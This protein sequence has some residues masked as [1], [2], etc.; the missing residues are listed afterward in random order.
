MNSGRSDASTS[1][2]DVS[3]RPLCLFYFTHPFGVLSPEPPTLAA[4]PAHIA[5]AF[6]NMEPVSP[7]TMWGTPSDESYNTSYNT[8]TSSSRP[9]FEL[10]NA[11]VHAA[12]VDLVSV[13]RTR[14]CTLELGARRDSLSSSLFSSDVWFNSSSGRSADYP[15]R[16]VPYNK[17]LPPLRLP[18][19]RDSSNLDSSDDLWPKK[20]LNP[21]K[22]S[23]PPIELPAVKVKIVRS[24]KCVRGVADELWSGEASAARD[25]RLR[26]RL[27]VSKP[28]RA[29]RPADLRRLL[30]TLMRRALAEGGSYGGGVSPAL[31]DALNTI[32]EAWAEP[33]SL[34][35]APP[36]GAVSRSRVTCEYAA[37]EPAV[38]EHAPLAELARPG[39]SP[40]LM[41]RRYSV[42]ETIMRKYRLAQQRSDSDESA[43]ATSRSAA[44]ASP[45][46]GDAG[47]RFAR[48]DRELMRKSAL[49][50]R[51][52]GR[53]D[54]RG[55]CCCADEPAPDC[56]RETRSLDGSRSELRHL[57]SGLASSRYSHA[58]AGWA[59]PKRQRLDSRDFR[60]SDEML[61]AA[62][63]NSYDRAEES[64]DRATR[65]D[66][67]ECTYRSHAHRPDPD[68]DATTDPF[69]DSD[70]SKFDE[71]LGRDVYPQ[72]TE[73]QFSDTATVEIKSSTAEDTSAP[74][75]PSPPHAHAHAHCALSDERSLSEA[76]D[77]FSAS[78]CTAK[79]A[80]RP[81]DLVTRSAHIDGRISEKSA[82]DDVDD[83]RVLPY[84]KPLTI[85]TAPSYEVLEIVVSETLNVNPV[86][87]IHAPA[88]ERLPPNPRPAPPAL[89]NTQNINIDEYVS[90]ILVESLNS[91]TDQ[92]E[93]M[94][95]SI[96]S[97]RKISIVEKEIKVKLQN[98]GVNTIVHLSPTSNNQIIFG[99]EELCHEE[100]NNNDAHTALTIREEA[101][102]V[103]SNNN[104]PPAGARCDCDSFDLHHENVNQAVLQ[105]IQKLFQDELH[106]LAPADYPAA[107]V[108]PEISHVEIS[109]VDVFIDNAEAALAAQQ[110][111]RAPAELIGGVG[112]GN[113]FPAAGDNPVV[114][115]FSA[116][117]HTDSMEVNTSS[118]DDADLI[119]SDC[120][121]LVDSLDD[122]NSPRSVLLRRAYSG[123]RGEL[124]R[125][126]IDVLDLLPE[127]VRRDD[128]PQPRDKP[129]SFFIG[130]KDNEC[131]CDKENVNVADRM[132]EKI[133]QRLYRRHRK[134]ELRMEC[135]RRTRTRAQRR[136]LERERVKYA[137]SCRERERS[138]HAQSCRARR[139]VERD[140]LAIVNALIDDV[141]AKIAQDEYKCMRIKHR[142]AR[143][144]ASKSDENVAKRTWRKELEPIDAREPF[145]AIKNGSVRFD[146]RD[147]R[148]TRDRAE[149]H[150]VHGKLSLRPPPVV[151][152]RAAK[153]I[154]QKSEIHD[155][156]K[157][158][159]ILE[160]LEY[161]NGSQS[162]PET[163][164][165]D[166][167]QNHCTK[168]KK[169]RIPV[170][171]YERAL[172][173]PNGEFHKN[174]NN[175]KSSGDVRGV[176]RNGNT[177][178]L[179]ADMLLEALAEHERSPPPRRA[180][181][182][183]PHEPRERA[184]S[185]RFHQVFDII[186]EE[187][188]SLS[189]D[190][191][192]EE[193][194]HAR[195]ASA[196]DIV[197]EYR[198][199]SERD[200]DD[201][202]PAPAP[203]RAERRSGD[204][205]QRST[206][207]A[208]ADTLRRSK[209]TKSAATSPMSDADKRALR[210]KHQTTMTS[211]SSKSAATSPLRADCGAP[212]PAAGAGPRRG[213]PPRGRMGPGA[214]RLSE[215]GV[216]EKAVEPVDV[217]ARRSVPPQYEAR[218]SVRAEKAP[219][220]E[221]GPRAR[222]PPA[223]RS[224]SYE[225]VAPGADDLARSPDEPYATND[226]RKT[227]TY[228][229]DRSEDDTVHP[230]KLPEF[231]G[232]GSAEGE[233][234]GTSS[235]SSESGGSLLC[236]LAPRWLAPGRA[237]RAARRREIAR[238]PRPAPP[239]PAPAQSPAPPDPRDATGGWSVTVAGSC[240]AALPADVEMRLRFPHERDAPPHPA[241][242]APQPQP[243]QE[244]TCRHCAACSCSAR[245]ARPRAPPLPPA[246]P[247]ARLSRTDSKLTLT[248][249][250]E[251]LDS[252]ILASKSTRKS[253]EQLPDVETYRA[254][255]SKLKSSVKTRRGYSLH[256]W[257]PDNEDAPI[258]YTHTTQCTHPQRH[259]DA[260]LV[261]GCRCWAAP[262]SPS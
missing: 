57:S 184:N 116:L 117:P 227:R 15:R 210:S 104:A 115:R 209:D 205:K 197:D 89:R 67:S 110:A 99:N 47:H 142:P 101:L 33:R 27:G 91:L 70:A 138:Q 204:G 98:T 24:K 176:E 86:P 46:P 41:R 183:A 122:P 113:Y 141:I 147:A 137:E 45:A 149:R 82:S 60:G 140:C 71:R 79:E 49:M 155:G 63:R 249:K 163:T 77:T 59:T 88:P 261:T 96:G 237:R 243:C 106:N 217:R 150:H 130:I 198:E 257:L 84:D 165:S 153:R 75:D 29:A 220:P 134:R 229:L 177:N 136:E 151:D 54:C 171:I 92:L 148:E 28:R 174:N 112:A 72:F 16:L 253:S 111:E 158:I 30:A 17:I 51:M 223:R 196:P 208:T 195:R 212:S 144:P 248:M 234:E 40:G 48:R 4:A 245:S 95:A 191:G 238:P 80:L 34:R 231:K 164:N 2:D 185:L 226:K 228:S 14:K 127:N 125:S 61:R 230:A 241:H 211:P 53:A 39:A 206:Q 169:S 254:S 13:A 10:G 215:E 43:P 93:C 124:V 218:R 201:A 66:T 168:N 73:R 203:L 5:R 262:S 207:P 64:R 107:A 22:F 189:L 160:I 180:S 214:A 55:C 25:L 182:P 129:E 81:V 250:K 109:N 143:I 123:R 179:I 199:P 12:P 219:R 225:R 192:A 202:P 242:S 56:G 97:D 173:S 108:M 260:G 114:P 83:D 50:R 62:M 121:S 221:R 38:M 146:T 78:L 239:P 162:S 156:N 11:T 181:V 159:E 133:K 19:P 87:D 186:P 224:L 58:A 120:T 240:R 235:D 1:T 170:P 74:S 26:R 188:S 246:A 52:W 252:S 157:C 119:G 102:S 233:V 190:S 126:A 193:L 175:R 166:E 244:C 37:Q 85:D 44:S 132:P 32:R 7:F 213:P 100:R 42:P 161:V 8:G 20:C 187:R 154:Y 94:N 256:C 259:S 31:R 90:N 135:A 18:S 36:R 145:K 76:S 167:N 23:L 69:T 128:T 194:A 247:H 232:G 103:E 35:A 105:Q 255:R 118:S 68:V 9:S 21:E 236:S 222:A 251:A 65:A 131:D 3:S 6:V 258:R 216:K 200:C 139:D 152:D 178:R 172:K